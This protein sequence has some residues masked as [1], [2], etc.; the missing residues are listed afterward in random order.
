[1]AGTHLLSAGAITGDDVCNL[2]EEKLGTTQD[3]MLDVTTGKIQ[4][5]VLSSGGILGMGNH[6]YAV[7]WSALKLDAE[8]QRFALDMDEEPL[9]TAP[10]FD[11]DE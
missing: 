2:Q 6:L 7:P 10:G 4:Y 1:M 3:I 9:K 11:K 8:Y 5:A